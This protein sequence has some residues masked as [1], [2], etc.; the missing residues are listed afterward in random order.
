LSGSIS[1]CVLWLCCLSV[2]PDIEKLAAHGFGGELSQWIANWLSERK[3]RVVV[4][5]HCSGWEA[6]LSRV[7]QGSVLSPL[8]FVIY[9]NDIDGSVNSKIL[10]FADDTKVS[11]LLLQRRMLMVYAVIYVTWSNGLNNGRCFSMLKN[12]K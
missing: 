10:K 11:T 2:F 9:I 1:N 8:L 5:A 4:N 12:A 3:Q 7:P 6:V